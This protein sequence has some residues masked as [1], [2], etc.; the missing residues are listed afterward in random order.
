MSSVVARVIAKPLVGRA[1]LI[2]PFG[3]PA[4]LLE[5]I[6]LR[7]QL[8]AEQG[9]SHI[10]QSELP[11]GHDLGRGGPSGLT[12]RCGRSCQALS[13]SSTKSTLSTM[14]PPLMHVLGPSSHVLRVGRP[15]VNQCLPPWV[16]ALPLRQ[17]V[18][19]QE[20]FV[21]QLQFL[22][23][24][25]RHVGQLRLHLPRRPAGLAAL[26]GVLHPRAGRLHH[27]IAGPA[28]PVHIVFAEPD[29]HVIHQPRHLE[30][31]QLPVAT[32][33]RQEFLGQFRSPVRHSGS[34]PRSSHARVADIRAPSGSRYGDT[35][36]PT[37]APRPN[38]SAAE[39]SR[40]P[41]PVASANRKRSRPSWYPG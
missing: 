10:D 1:P 19:P 18:L 31:L 5:G 7:S 30:A 37:R 26:G 3:E 9:T 29:S 15:P 13:T 39:R 23:A 20:V 16:V 25:P 17:P 38:D 21:V 34:P 14:H 8:P 40:S 35:T 36:S 32:M 22:Q 27:L 28:A 6:G 2:E 24:G 41:V 11:I 33:L 12:E 4:F